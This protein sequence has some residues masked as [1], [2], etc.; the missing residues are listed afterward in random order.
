M[1]KIVDVFTENA[2]EPIGPYAQA[3]KFGDLV[4]V[5]GQ[6]PLDP[7]TGNLVSADIESETTQVLENLKAVVE[8]S[9]SSME[10]VVKVTIYLA[11]IQDFPK[12]NTI[13]AE[14]FTNKPA[15]ATVEVSHLPKGARIEMDCIAVVEK[16]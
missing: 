9:S 2:P 13:Y 10:S 11:N 5:S 16:K 12:V 4:F 15:R 14:Y 7:K 6:I 3:K 8:A 1:S